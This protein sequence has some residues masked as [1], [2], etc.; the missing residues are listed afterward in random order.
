VL[1]N[2]FRFEEF[3]C[4]TRNAFAPSVMLAAVWRQIAGAMYKR[5]RTSGV[6]SQFTMPVRGTLSNRHERIPSSVAHG[7]DASGVDQPLDVLG[8]A[9]LLLGAP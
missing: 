1:S 6:T 8:T 5:E 7:D 3:H 9:E 4:A 2:V